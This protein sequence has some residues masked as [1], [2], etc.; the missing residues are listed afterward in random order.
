METKHFDPGPGGFFG[1]NEEDHRLEKDFREGDYW[2]LLT[3]IEDRKS[4]V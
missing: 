4:V 3:S 2:G 1:Y